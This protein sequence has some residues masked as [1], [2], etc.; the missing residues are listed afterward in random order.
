MLKNNLT[1]DQDLL[2]DVTVVEVVSGNCHM[3]YKVTSVF[4]GVITFKR[5]DEEFYVYVK[6]LVP[7]LEFGTVVNFDDLLEDLQEAAVNQEV[8]DYQTEK[9]VSN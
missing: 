7:T 5:K 8:I 1:L 2:E 6:D 4:N 9:R 3:F